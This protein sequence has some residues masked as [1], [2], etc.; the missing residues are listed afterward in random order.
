MALNSATVLKKNQVQTGGSVRLTRG[1]GNAPVRTLPSGQTAAPAVPQEARV[2]ESNNEY[3]IIEV[4]CSCG[5]TMHIQCN[6]AHLT[7]Q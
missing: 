2:I 6:Y 3:A 7:Q 4:K 5:Q 1:G